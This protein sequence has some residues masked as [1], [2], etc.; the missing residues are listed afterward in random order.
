MWAAKLACSV[1]L[2]MQFV[3]PSLAETVQSIKVW[4][5][6]TESLPSSVVLDTFRESCFATDL[7]FSS[8]I[9]RLQANRA[10]RI[11]MDAVERLF[12][13]VLPHGRDGYVLDAQS[14]KLTVLL[15]AYGEVTVEQR[16]L[17]RAG[18]FAQ[19]LPVAANR[20]LSD[21]LNSLPNDTIGIKSCTLIA[22][23]SDGFEL[24]KSVR[25]LEFD[26]TVVSDWRVRSVGI[27]PTK[28]SESASHWFG[29]LGL[30]TLNLVSRTND[31]QTTTVRIEYSSIITSGDPPSTFELE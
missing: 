25:E 8:V 4:E 31:D 15:A 26:G 17:A 23:V 1:L 9:F 13:G 24:A 19:T 30:S 28:R 22:R 27:G 14:G 2:S 3:A 7:D 18:S 5:E 12:S 29:S 11:G 6:P 16:R 10:S 20:E 21:P